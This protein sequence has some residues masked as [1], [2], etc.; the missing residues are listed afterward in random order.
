MPVAILTAAVTSDRRHFRKRVTAYD[1]TGLWPGALVGRGAIATFL[2][3][4]E[5][6]V[7]RWVAKHGF[8]AFIGPD[9]RLWSDAVLVDAW[10]LALADEQRARQQQDQ[11]ARSLIG[12]RDR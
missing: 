5:R 1:G 9:R 3:R 8:P 2:G 12:S 10:I 11:P 7:S 6:T 4:S